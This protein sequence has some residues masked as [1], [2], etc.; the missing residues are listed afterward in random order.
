MTTVMKIKFRSFVMGK[1][2]S[3]K[4]PHFEGV[5]LR[6]E[7]PQNEGLRVECSKKKLQI[8]F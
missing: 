2:I 4:E 3:N 1:T 8:Y 6:V 5:I 7:N